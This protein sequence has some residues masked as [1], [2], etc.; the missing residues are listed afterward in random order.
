MQ[1]VDAGACTDIMESSKKQTNVSGIA[2]EAI[3]A[4]ILR[5]TMHGLRYLHSNDKIHRDIKAGNILMNLGGEVLLAD[6]G[7]SAQMKKGVK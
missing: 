4:T 7:V 1:I 5:E 6:F 3:I 2:D